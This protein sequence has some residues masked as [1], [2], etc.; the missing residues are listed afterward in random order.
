MEFNDKLA[1]ARANNIS[2]MNVARLR[3]DIAI[4]DALRRES[5]KSL[6]AKLE[7]IY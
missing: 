5:I 3:S 6:T 1:Q 7:A 2:T 4:N